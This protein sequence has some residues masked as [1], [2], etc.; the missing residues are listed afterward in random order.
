MNMML[1]STIIQ[2]THR[3]VE[4]LHARG[5]EFIAVVKVDAAHQE[6]D[7]LSA[8]AKSHI[9]SRAAWRL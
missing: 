4:H 5:R 7:E 6:G 8:T 2:T 1:A 9:W 3:D